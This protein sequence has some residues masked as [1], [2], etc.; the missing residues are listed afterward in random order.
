M[1]S[2]MI[3]MALVALGALALASIRRIPEGQ[4]YTL[5]RVGG[6]TR[7]VPSGTHFMVPLIE[8]VAHKISLTGARVP[9]DGLVAPD[10]RYK[11]I[12]YFQVLDPVR[13]DRVIDGVDGLVQ[14]RTRTL[15]GEADLPAGENGRRLWLKQA[16]NSD[17]RERGLIVTRVDLDSLHGV[18]TLD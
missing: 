6:H 14:T 3:L 18:D 11:G 4:V 7:V 17:L 9:V 5:R 8:R 15:F 16:L 12:V 2:P 10:G 13:A 1:L